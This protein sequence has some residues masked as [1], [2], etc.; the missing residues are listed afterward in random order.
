VSEALRPWV[1]KYE[2]CWDERLERLCAVAE[3]RQAA[4]HDG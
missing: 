1:S 4:N 3:A 2:R